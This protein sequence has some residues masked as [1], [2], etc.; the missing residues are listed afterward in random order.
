MNVFLININEI[1]VGERMRSVKPK[2]K[3]IA[4]SMKVYGQLQPIIVDADY[5]LIDGNHRLAAAESIGME[6]IACV[7]REETDELFVRELEL[8]TNIMREDMTWQE[9]AKAIATLEELKRAKNP[10]ISQMQIAQAAGL[11]SQREVSQAK[12]ITKMI[13]LFPEIG[14]A[15]SINQALSW[16]KQKASQ[17]VRRKEVE[18]EAQRNEIVASVAD[19]VIL[20]DSTEVIK[21]LPSESVHAFITD[22]PFGIDY[23]SRKQGTV[24]TLNSYDD[25]EEAYMRLLDMAPEMY[26]VLKPDGWVIWF[27]GISWYERAR[28]AFRAAGFT[29]DEIPVI[30]DRREG[31]TFTTRP[32]HY[33]TRSYDIALHMHKGDPQIVRR[34]LPNIISVPP[35]ATTERELMVERPV[36]LYAELIR[37][38]TI[39]GEV[40][41]D[42]FTGSGSC[43]AAAAMLKRKYIGVEL[44]PER[45]AVA[46]QKIIANTPE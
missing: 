22:P 3:E 43:L 36:E 35:V 4:E 19:R 31:K 12:T 13:E 46:I 41:C 17:I 14:E 45:R 40:V 42:L 37:R 16:A 29:V 2:Y 7:L 34:N 33:F 5:N 26:R 23:G 11:S 21:T 20:G 24:G 32:D 27:L 8:E 28:D 30:W 6:Q 38:L 10:N 44:N 15:K 9:R 25:D 39:E 18:D 1:H